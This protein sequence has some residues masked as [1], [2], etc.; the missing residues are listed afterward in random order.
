MA[1]LGDGDGHPDRSGHF[2]SV[3]GG[4]RPTLGIQKPPIPGEPDTFPAPG[5]ASPPGHMLLQPVR[6]KPTLRKL[7]LPSLAFSQLDAPHHH[8]ETPRKM[9]GLINQ[10]TLSQLPL[11][12]SEVTSCVSGYAFGMTALLTYHN[13]DPQ[14][15][16]G[17]F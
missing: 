4:E 14:A 11:I 15:L 6:H 17:K 5:R 13:P 9:P 2:E 7:L 12:A 8:P 10:V 16:E 3:V 1:P